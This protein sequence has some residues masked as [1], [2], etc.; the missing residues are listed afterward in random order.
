MKQ[1]LFFIAFTLTSSAFL[2]FSQ[3]YLLPKVHI[4]DISIGLSAAQ[5]KLARDALLPGETLSLEALAHFSDGTTKVLDKTDT[6][7]WHVTPK[8][9]VTFSNN[10]ALIN[11]AVDSFSITASQGELLSKPLSFNVSPSKVNALDIETINASNS[12]TLNV[13]SAA[14]LKVIA[15]LNDKSQVDVT[16]TVNWQHNEHVEIEQ[17]IV[18][19][20]SK[21]QSALSASLGMVTSSVFNVEI[22][23]T[24]PNTCRVPMVTININNE[25]RIFTC[26]LAMEYEKQSHLFQEWGGNGPANMSV[27]RLTWKKAQTLCQK[28]TPSQRLP[29][30]EELKA[31]YQHSA[32]RVSSVGHSPVYLAWGWPT[33]I[34]YWSSTPYGNK[35]GQHYFV[36]LY[37]GYAYNYKDRSR[38]YV[39]CVNY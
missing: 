22:N 35:K 20:K 34:L 13:N 11:E 17:G 10:L 30:V 39:T 38:L 5:R 12:L 14:Q 26:P 6:Y 28:Q 24:T 3:P 32:Q 7:Q 23:D 29:T 36:G 2:W 33:N 19:A 1:L 31:L 15:T 16:Q 18:E 37:N 21:G 27:P 25:R 4:T 9:A 8:N